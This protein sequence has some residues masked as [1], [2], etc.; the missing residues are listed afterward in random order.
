MLKLLDVLKTICKDVLQFVEV[1]GNLRR[2]QG[3]DLHHGDGPGCRGRR[4]LGA[5]ALWLQAARAIWLLGA[6]ATLD[7]SAL[8][9]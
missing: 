7:T 4:F 8:S 2:L 3:K 6:R 5:R 1:P 9:C